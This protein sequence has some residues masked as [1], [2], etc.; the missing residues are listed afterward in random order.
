MTL[1]PILRA[2]AHLVNKSATT[3]NA[4][5]NLNSVLTARL[6]KYYAERG[7]PEEKYDNTDLSAVQLQTAKEALF[8]VRQV[9][10]AL[11]LAETNQPE[12]AAIQTEIPVLGTRDVSHLRILISIVFKWG[13]DALLDR[14][15]PNR[16]TPSLPK[17]QGSAFVVDLTRAPEDYKELCDLTYQLLSVVLP[18]GHRGQLPQSFVANLL[19]TRH[20]SDILKPCITLGWLPKALSTPLIPVQDDIRPLT[21][22]LLSLPPSQIILSLGS[23]I[24]IRPPLPSYVH[25]T[26][27]FLLGRQLVRPGG[28]RGL[29]A[30]IFGEGI[31][32]SESG[33]S[34]DKLEHFAKA[35]QTVPPSVPSQ[36][37][38]RKVT[39]QLLALLADRSDAP[40]PT[41]RRAAAFSISR[42][43]A[44][45]Y[46]NREESLSIL[47]PR[48]HR[49]F[50][51]AAELLPREGIAEAEQFTTTGCISTL[52]TILINTDP[53]PAL[54]STIFTPIT[55]ALYAVLGCLDSKQTADPALKE[56]VKGLLGTWSRIVSAREVEEVCWGIIEGGGGYWKIDITGDIVQT[57]RPEVTESPSVFTPEALEEAE[58]SGKLGIDSNLLD[59]RPDPVHFVG[60]LKT[61]NRPD[62]SSSLFVRLLEAYRGVKLDKGDPLRAL[63]YLQLIIQVQTQLADAGSST[64]IL[65]K[66]EHIL[67]FV[68]YALE[69]VQMSRK[70]PTPARRPKRTGLG[71]DD[72]RI[73]PNSDDEMDSGDSDDEDEGSASTT[74]DEITVTALN[75]LLALLEA[76]S[77]MSVRTNPALN[78]IF[79][80]LEPLT[81]HS[82]SLR[83][84]ARE[85]RMVLTARLAS[86]SSPS[87]NFPSKKPGANEDE[88]PKAVYQKALAL[89]Q[90][91]LL[92]VRA[93]GLLLLRQLASS[94]S[95]SPEDPTRL[96][97]A[98]DPALVPGVLSIFLQSIQDEDSYIFLNATQGLAAMVE[99]FG[100]EVLRGLVA[101]YIGGLG[102]VGAGV[103]D[104]GE[105]DVRV[106]IGEALGQ[107]V[108]RCGETLPSYADLLVPPLAKVVR[109]SHLPTILRTSSISLLA[110][111]A[112]TNALALFPYA[113]DLF[114]GMVDLL[115]LESVP[116]TSSPPKQ[117]SKPPELNPDGKENGKDSRKTKVEDSHEGNEQDEV[118]GSISQPSLLTMD[119]YPTLANSKSPPLRRAALHFLA[120]LVRACISRVYDM[121]IT[122]MLIPDA[123]M[124][125]ARTT[126]SYVASTDEDAVVKV[127]AREVREGLGQLSNALLGL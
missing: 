17:A 67:M 35:V 92:P 82:E 124:A 110:Q 7:V 89:L 33:V 71:L 28:I 23:I 14:V 4:T 6:S 100:R 39:P 56:T 48:V 57:A 27:S 65:K 84:L 120:L 20:L 8:I 75:L 96:T 63:L 113:T 127:M 38:F 50:L 51:Q 22:R 117:P 69:D 112:G 109:S 115:Q 18:P 125:R 104:Q 73:V 52:Q 61:M 111:M 36:E 108:R 106:R 19:L 59:L 126:L 103:L 44:E 55:A 42:L 91:P 11:V 64:N 119:S 97:S 122:G 54:L 43:L 94:K 107:V 29:C 25:K 40:H 47:L 118:T 62:V 5:E 32:T 24:T 77:G 2:A 79:V 13:T 46:K 34:L 83:P 102:G 31:E 26:C 16:T 1:D 68:K 41:Y 72:L 116:V 87:E 3:N 99:G 121:G 98:L 37:F 95:P 114:G 86:T 80:L 12:K 10:D 93:H 81:K 74:P 53:S 60:F 85:A 123:Y 30:A 70:L 45:G 88:D 15:V 76:N 66:P 105:V 78:D 90:D 49:P 58:K 9:H 21:M 101:D